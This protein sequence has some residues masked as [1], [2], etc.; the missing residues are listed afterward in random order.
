M[1]TIVPQGKQRP[2]DGR[3]T[4][5]LQRVYLQDVLYRTFLHPMKSFY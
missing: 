3:L 2:F 1:V 4:P 5:L